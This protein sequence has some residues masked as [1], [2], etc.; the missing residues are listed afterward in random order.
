M[1][2]SQKVDINGLVGAHFVVAAF[3]FLFGIVIGSFLNVC[4]TRIP[5]G[6]SIVT[7]G[8]VGSTTQLEKALKANGLK[9]LLVCQPMFF[10]NGCAVEDFNGRRHCYPPAPTER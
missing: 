5:E 7:P 3:F 8:R 9:S 6:L 1:W 2:Q 4:I 10:T